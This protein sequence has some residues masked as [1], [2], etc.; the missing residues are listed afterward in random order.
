MP[1]AS[2][3]DRIAVFLDF[4]DTLHDFTGAYRGA[5]LQAVGAVCLAAGPSCD[6]ARLAE[7]C[8]AAW[9]EIW[10]RFV[11]GEIG[12][13]SLWAE[14]SAC[15]L[16]LAGM[17]PDPSLA[18]AVHTGYLAGM[19]AGLRLYPETS[20]ALGLLREARPQ[21]VVGLLTNG[22]ALTQRE[23]LARLGLAGHFRPLV[24]SGELGCAKPDPRFF[25]T[26][27]D[28]AGVHPRSAVMIGDHPV[29]DVAGAQRVGL[30]AIWLN[31]GSAPWPA[32]AGSAPEAI[33]GDLAAAIRQALQWLGTA[34]A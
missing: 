21:P 26:A 2:V 5:L 24:I 34:P 31:R 1:N 12:E 8:A 9:A 11:R 22:P 10:E 33:C 13:T 3:M 19:D 30:R 32:D 14:R 27:L 18:A 17:A 15:A 25:K 20:A 7:R 16:T 6:P 28:Q 4:D 23:R 29:A